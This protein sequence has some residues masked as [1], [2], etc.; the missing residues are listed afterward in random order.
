MNNI[1]SNSKGSGITPGTLH[2]LFSSPSG[3]A[4]F[5]T[6]SSV[7]GMEAWTTLGGVMLKDLEARSA[8]DVVAGSE[9]SDL[10]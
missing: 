10:R 9:V 6:G 1:L 7:N 4:G 3:A 8:A 2:V 5:V